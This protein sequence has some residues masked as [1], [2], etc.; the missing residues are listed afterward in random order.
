MAKIRIKIGVSEIKLIE[1]SDIKKKSKNIYNECEL[2]S[3]RV[4]NQSISYDELIIP[5]KIRIPQEYDVI[6][7]YWECI[8]TA[9][10]PKDFPVP[11]YIPFFLLERSKTGQNQ[12]FYR[13][14]SIAE[15]VFEQFTAPLQALGDNHKIYLDIWLLKTRIINGE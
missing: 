11:K 6:N 2:F 10:D 15:I 13:G 12:W 4:L 8:R 9:T 7:E 3:K 1:I 5:V 14:D